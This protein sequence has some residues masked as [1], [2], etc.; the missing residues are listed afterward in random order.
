MGACMLFAEKYAKK[1]ELCIPTQF[2]SVIIR[3]LP[4]RGAFDYSVLSATTGSF[5]AAPDAGIR[6]DIRVRSML[7]QMRSTA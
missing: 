2:L 5:L 3:F 7:M 6:P 4:W 1:E